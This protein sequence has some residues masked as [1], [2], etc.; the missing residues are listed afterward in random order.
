MKRS[1]RSWLWRV[2]VEQEID[3][4]M[5]FHLE[6]RTRE[7]VAGGLDPESARRVALSRLGDLQDIK[8]E[9]AGLGRKRDRDMRVRQWLDEFRYDVKY[10]LRQLRRSPGF[11]FVAAL[12]LALGIGA[13]AAIFALVDATLLRPLAFSEPDRLVRVWTRTSKSERAAVSPLDML[14]WQDRTRHFQA[15]GGYAPNVASMV[16]AGADGTA[17]TIPRQWVTAGFFDVLGVKAVAGRM[18][19]A[20]D[21]DQAVDAVVIGEGLWRARFG[22][23]RSLV[24]R[25]IRLDGEPYTVV[26]VAP[27]EFEWMGNNSLWGL[28]SIPRDPAVRRAVA[29]SVIGRLK[30]G[31][32][33]DAARTDLGSVAASLAREFPDTNRDRAVTMEPLRDALVGT[34]LRRTSLLFV[35]VVGVVLLICCG[36]VANLLLARGTVRTRELAVRSALGAG[37]RRIVRQLLTESIV[38]STIGGLLAL[39]AGAFLLEVAPRLIPPGVLPADITIQF[40][41]RVVTFCAATALAVGLLFGLAPAWQ[42]TRLSTANT[43]AAD[44]RTGTRRGGRLRALLVGAEIA[45]AVVLLCGAGLLLRTLLVI[46]N[47][48]SGYRAKEVLTLLVDPVGSRYPTP[49]A[50][51]QFYDDIEH[52][53]RAL[54]G[55]RDVAWSTTVPLGDSYAGRWTFE[56]V[57]DA[58]VDAAQRPTTNIEIASDSYFST[59][60][61][62]I[63]A[64][65]GFTDG[66]TREHV[67]VCIVSESVVRQHLGGRSPIGVRLA[68]RPANAPDATPVIRE[69]VGVAR[70]LKARPDES[71]G[72]NQVYAPIT[73]LIID[74]IF[75]LVRPSSG[76]AS[77]LAPSVRAAIG[78][79]DKDQLT[80]VRDVVTLDDVADQATAHY[81]FRAVLVM[82]FAVLALLLAMVGV[83]GILAYSVQQRVREIGVRRAL[84]ASTGQVFRLVAA[85]GGRVVGIGAGI[86]LIVAMLAARLLTTLLFGVEPLDPL[87]FAV[88]VG[89]L[90]FTAAVSIA[91]PAWRAMRIDPASALRA[92]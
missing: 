51:Q 22:A 2:P 58:P 65:R 16:L 71:E 5:A 34:D 28:R 9:C 26:G 52:E 40:D 75:L 62:P 67:P 6:M 49:Q 89:L 15:I 85:S 68:M 82:A 11:T 23:D 41:G 84:G 32:T 21:N 3:E 17:E 70:Q 55:I 12:T 80:S 90:V 27:K 37:R 73:Q 50:M 83:F 79:I 20:T 77:A 72:L 7:L 8:R 38:L 19:T 13:N 44:T 48:D 87:T 57:G 35:G 36:N 10:A 24:G 29:L 39:V 59:I 25:T 66:D 56:V 46:D 61:L 76:P 33:I 78:R 30:P 42:A 53:I 43:M 47:V 60:D 74:D 54:P 18:F 45:T 1:L 31:V 4:E 86:G 88:V 63:V 92:D 91:A 81:R 69:I 64:G 14:D